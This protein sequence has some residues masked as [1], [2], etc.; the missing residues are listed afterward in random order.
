[1]TAEVMERTLAGSSSPPRSP[2]NPSQADATRPLTGALI[3]AMWG[4]KPHTQLK[5]I[6]SYYI[7][8][9]K[10]PLLTVSVAL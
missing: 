4:L 5:P 10:G 7:P 9:I 3:I 6:N 1:M 2:L 8:L